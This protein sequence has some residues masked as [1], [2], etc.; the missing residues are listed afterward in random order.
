MEKKILNLTQHKATAE[1]IKAGVM[2][3]EDEKWRSVLLELL[4]F[5]ELPD[6]VE[7]LGAA[8]NIAALAEEQGKGAQKA[9]IGGAPF[10]MSRLE[11][12][13]KERGFVTVYAFSK[14][15]SEE[16]EVD[17]KVIKTQ[18]FKHLGFVEVEK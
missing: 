10:L 9:M 2:D 4:T 11:K 6:N 5:E 8:Q 3:I 18:V 12:A 7:I 13:L 15:V 16:S 14:R 1:Q 17:G